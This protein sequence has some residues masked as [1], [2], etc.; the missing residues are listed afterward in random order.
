MSSSTLFRIYSGDKHYT[1]ILLKNGTYLEVKN[2]D[3]NN[4]KVTFATLEEWCKSHECSV[5]DAVK[6]SNQVAEKKE[7]LRFKFV[8]DT[9]LP[10]TKWYTA[11]GQF[12]WDLWYY[13]I[14]KTLDKSL[15][16][17][18]SVIQAFNAFI[19]IDRKS[20]V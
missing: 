13:N 6:S 2:P 20:V 5:K 18:P 8:S 15:L 1:A 9:T 4:K 19:D 11:K 3:T 16:K 12:I 17:N 7:K 10:Y 14:M